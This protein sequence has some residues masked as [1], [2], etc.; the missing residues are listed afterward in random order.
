M[1]QLMKAKNHVNS[2]LVSINLNFGQGVLGQHKLIN[3]SSLPLCFIT[4]IQTCTKSHLSRIKSFMI[5]IFDLTSKNKI[6]IFNHPKK[7][8]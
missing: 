4:S 8:Y 3:R 6:L 2:Y 5:I 1:Y 7:E